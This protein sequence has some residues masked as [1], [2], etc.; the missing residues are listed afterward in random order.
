MKS[1]SHIPCLYWNIQFS[2]ENIIIFT[3][4]VPFLFVFLRFF[5]QVIHFCK[6]DYVDLIETNLNFLHIFPLIEK[7][8]PKQ[9]P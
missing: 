9:V 4:L 8:W 5:G 1:H 7:T 3:S 2:W 6:F